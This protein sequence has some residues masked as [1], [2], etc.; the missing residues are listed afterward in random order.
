MPLT[1]PLPVT[2]PEN[3]DPTTGVF[4]AMSA[5]P[6]SLADV[7]PAGLTA[8]QRALLTIDGTVTQFLEAYALEPVAIRVLDHRADKAGDNARWLACDED[9]DVLHRRS[10]LQGADSGQLFAFAESVLLTARLP[11]EMRLALEEE[12]GG[13]GKILLRV[14]PESRREALWFGT[15]QLASVSPGVSLGRVLTRTYRIIAAGVPLML[16]TEHFPLD[17]SRQT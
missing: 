3:F 7:D 10:M 4:V 8:F 11:A 13:L 1:R 9:A 5:R 2:A 15:Q 6:P 14:A 12:S 17:D 16:I